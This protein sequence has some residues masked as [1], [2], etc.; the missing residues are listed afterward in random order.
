MNT[1]KD[2]RITCRPPPLGKLCMPRVLVCVAANRPPLAG[3]N[4]YPGQVIG[5]AF[6]LPP[7]WYD[8]QGH[9]YLSIVWAKPARWWK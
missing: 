5:V 4:R 2:D 1:P 3:L 6:R 9:P 8:T 7:F